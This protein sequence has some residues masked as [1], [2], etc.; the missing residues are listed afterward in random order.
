MLAPFSCQRPKRHFSITALTNIKERDTDF[1]EQLRSDKVYRPREQ[2][3]ELRSRLSLFLEHKSFKQISRTN[4]AH[5]TSSET[6]LS[7]V[8]A[9]HFFGRHRESSPRRQTLNGSYAFNVVFWFCKGLPRFINTASYDLSLLQDQQAPVKQ[10]RS[11]R[12][13]SQKRSSINLRAH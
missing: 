6:A 13:A 7:P 5:E 11:P 3:C 1:D 10:M 4:S 12:L 8:D 9:M 2:A